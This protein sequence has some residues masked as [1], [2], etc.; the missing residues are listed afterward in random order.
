MNGVR[1]LPG[2]TFAKGSKRRAFAA[3][4]R[5]RFTTG[6]TRHEFSHPL[7]QMW[8]HP[9][10]RQ[11]SASCSSSTAQAGTARKTWP[12]IRSQHRWK[13]ESLNASIC[14]PLNPQKRPFVLHNMR[15]ATP[16]ARWTVARRGPS[17]PVKTTTFARIVLSIPKLLPVEVASTGL[18][19]NVLNDL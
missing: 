14:S 15:V 19:F 4:L 2:L 6:R 10:Y 9:L 18:R 13:R 12:C 7:R 1:A 5:L 3:C 16:G 11:R 17:P 8:S